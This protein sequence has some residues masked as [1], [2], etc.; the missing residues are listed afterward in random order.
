MSDSTA[1]IQTQ[2]IATNADWQARKEAAIARG[3]G[4]LAAIYIERAKNAEWSRPMIPQFVSLSGS[5][6]APRGKAR[7]NPCS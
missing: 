5:T 6:N 7:R 4:N 3:E 1:A 2:A